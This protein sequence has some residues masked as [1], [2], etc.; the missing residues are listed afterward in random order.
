MKLFLDTAN[1][2]DIREAVQWGIVDGVTT[3][4]SLVSKEK[5]SFM[6]ILPGIC[7]LVK[8]PVSAEVIAEDWQG[9]VEEARQLAAVANNVVIKIPI[10]LEG[11]Q[12]VKTLAGEGIKTNVTLIFS[13]N[14]ALMAARAGASYVS[15][16]LGRIYDIGGSGMSLLRDMVAVFERHRITTEI[17][18]ASIRH[19]EHVTQAALTG[20]SIATIPYPIL[21][22]MVAHPLTDQGLEKFLVDWQRSAAKEK[23]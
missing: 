14:Q 6:E 12:A 5:E 13:V 23:L 7:R 8:G 3:N 16:F 22:Q 20:A 9:M 1:L 18:A 21:R 11:L 10:T 19:Q 17:I 4:P 2:E 15:P